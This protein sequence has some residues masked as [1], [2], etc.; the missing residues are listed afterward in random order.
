MGACRVNSVV[1]GC[2]DAVCRL[3]HVGS[4]ATDKNRS[5]VMETIRGTISNK[6]TRNELAKD[7]EFHLRFTRKGSLCG[8]T[9]YFETELGEPTLTT[10]EIYLLTLETG[11][12][13]DFFCR[14]T[15][16]GNQRKRIEIMSSSDGIH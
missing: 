14:N 10:N 7:V 16:F 8:V 3:I 11:Q 15:A 9:G 13:F 6:T 2:R 1:I 5:Y 4:V 12:Q